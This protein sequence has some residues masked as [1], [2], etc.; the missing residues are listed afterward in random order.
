MKR[1]QNGD[2]KTHPLTGSVAKRNKIFSFFEKKSTGDTRVTK[3]K[4]VSQI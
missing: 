2:E 3:N 4:T 1:H